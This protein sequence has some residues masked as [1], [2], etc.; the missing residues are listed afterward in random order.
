MDARV[1]PIT[2]RIKADEKYLVTCGGVV[3]W[4]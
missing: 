1:H 3:S 2:I 4:G